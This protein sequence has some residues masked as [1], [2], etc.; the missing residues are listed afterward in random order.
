MQ[1]NATSVISHCSGV[2]G[3]GG[4]SMD[5]GEEDALAAAATEGYA[6]GGSRPFG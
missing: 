6:G 2:G 1:R 5:A 3:D 4:S